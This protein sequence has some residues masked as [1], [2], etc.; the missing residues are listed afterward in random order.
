MLKNIAA[1]IIARGGRAFYVGGYVRNQLMGMTS[2][3]DED[4]DIEVYGLSMEELQI[5]LSVYGTTRQVGKSFPV[6]KVS[7]HNEWDFTIPEEPGLTFAA[8]CARRD[9]TINSMMMDILSGEIIDIYGGRQDIAGELIRHTSPDVFT[10]DPLRVYRAMYFAARL[11]FKIHPSTLEL[12]SGTDL[13]PVIKERIYRV[14]RKLLLFSPRPSIGLRYMQTTGVLKR[15]HP[16]L[17]SLIDCQQ[18]SRNHPEGD[19][20]EHTLLVVDQ[21]A[22]LRTS[23][24][25]PEALM[26]AAL[27]H[28]VGKP[29][30]TRISGDKVTAYGHDV[31][32]EKLARAF[33]LELTQNKNL[34]N[35]AA[36]LIKEHMHP[37]L[38]YK[39]RENVSDR[40]I[41]KL[42]SRVNL[43]ELLL[44]AEADF[45]GRHNT[46]DFE[47]VNN[48]FVERLSRLGLTLNDRIDPLVKGRDLLQMGIQ[49]GPAYTQAL[50]LAFELQMEGRSKEA[51]L[52]LVLQQTAPQ[53]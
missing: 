21:A 19:V 24:S 42:V 46:R 28:D 44:M 36:L 48:W 1:D 22:R 45:M 18:S 26:F 47:M 4:I 29:R 37:I 16:L 12:I 20:W 38:L 2:D 10:A 11:D 30:T 53:T 6:L 33:L 41:R 8:A 7:G 39:D 34:I 52:Q 49:P 50:Q 17:F 23:S 9:F 40:A 13:S 5:L 51:I 25:N 43:K 31:L 27:L 15:M 32:G 35:S 3:E 14:L